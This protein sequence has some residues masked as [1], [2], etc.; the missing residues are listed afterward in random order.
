MP[1]VADVPVSQS[2][3]VVDVRTVMVK[4]RHASVADPTVFGPEW[5]HHATRVAEAKDVAVALQTLP[6]VVVGYLLDRSA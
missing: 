2:Y 5:A 1:A 3:A 6:L 4:L